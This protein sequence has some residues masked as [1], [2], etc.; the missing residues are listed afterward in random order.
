MNNFRH[1]A[2]AAALLGAAA[3]LAVTSSVAQFGPP[4]GPP[5]GPAK[6]TAPIDLTG[7]WVSIVTEDWRFRMVTPPK[8]DHDGVF[9]TPAGDAIA[10]AWDPAKDEAA[11]NQCKAYGAAAIM[12]MPGRLR[13]SWAD[14]QTLQIE[15]DSGRQTR[16]LHFAAVPDPAEPTSQGVSRAEWLPHG[17]GG[18]APPAN[19]S[20]KVVTTHM[21]EGYLRKNGVPYSANAV[22]TEYFDVLQQPDGSHWLVVKSIVEDAGYLAAASITS[23]NFRKQN[24]RSGWD[25]QPCTSR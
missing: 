4:S 21:K 11:G 24:D 23:S 10:Q 20:L 8:G 9:L 2:L 3:L 19:G 16:L 6:Q 12:R 1:S 25:P 15:I 7:Q 13:I 14:D 18:G 17:G 5:P 22:L